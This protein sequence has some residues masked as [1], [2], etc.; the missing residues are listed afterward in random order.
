M[1]E[2]FLRL[3]VTAKFK[4]LS[5]WRTENDSVSSVA[6]SPYACSPGQQRT[7]RMFPAM[8]IQTPDL[9]GSPSVCRDRSS[10]RRQWG[11]RSSMVWHSQNSLQMCSRHQHGFLVRPRPVSQII[12]QSQQLRHLAH[13]SARWQDESPVSL[14]VCLSAAPNCITNLEPALRILPVRPQ[15]IR[16]VRFSIRLTRLLWTDIAIP[17][18]CPCQMFRRRCSFPPP[19]PDKL[20]RR[21]CLVIRC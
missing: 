8:Q 11:I 9:F 19:D 7:H 10:V 21:K 3:T 12:A 6:F 4:G 18:I 16:A 14:R 15:L 1:Q 17:C 5:S 13:T 20:G 2:L